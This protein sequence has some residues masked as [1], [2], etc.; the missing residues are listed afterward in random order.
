MS[1]AVFQEVAQLRTQANSLSNPRRVPH[2]S[3]VK[4]TSRGVR[5]AQGTTGCIGIQ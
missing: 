1:E 4:A 5:S 3:D 2:T